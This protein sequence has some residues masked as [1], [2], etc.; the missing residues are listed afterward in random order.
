MRKPRRRRTVI[1]LAGLVAVAGLV[2]ATLVQA[3]AATA[4]TVVVLSNAHGEVLVAA[5]DVTDKSALTSTPLTQSQQ[6]A[7]AAGP[8]KATQN[9]WLY[10]TGTAG[11]GAA[12]AAKGTIT[13]AGAS[14]V[15]EPYLDYYAIFNSTTSRVAW[16][17]N[18]PFN[19]DSVKQVDDWHV[20]Y[21]GDPFTVTGAPAGS[22]TTIGA[23]SADVQWAT[24]EQ[25]T[26]FSQHSWD[27]VSFQPSGFGQIFRVRYDVTG[28]FQFGSTFY[29]VTGDDRYF[30]VFS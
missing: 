20:D 29:T 22:T 18:A 23:T 2:A 14:Y 25:N 6:K 9:Q 19:A 24:T 1:V 30:G 8:V 11:A 12:D 15:V 28:V 17:G 26:W 3:N 10:P 5:P 7:A 13:A 4:D 27:S 21:F 16:T